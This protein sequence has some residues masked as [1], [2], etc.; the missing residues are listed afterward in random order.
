[1]KWVHAA[2]LLLSGLLCLRAN[3][4]GF[5]PVQARISGVTGSVLFSGGPGKQ[6]VVAGRG[7]PF[8][9]GNILDTT[10]GGRAVVSLSDGSVVIVQPGSV[11]TFKDFHQAGSLRE[12]FDIGLGQ[13][14]VK[15]NHF[16]GKPNPYRMNSPTASI[17]VRGTEFSITVDSAGGTKVVVFEGAVEVT[18]LSD[19]SRHALIEGGH[20]VFVVPGFD[21]QLFIPGAAD[22]ARGDN[23]RASPKTAGSQPTA[24]Q[25]QGA[26]GDRDQP[27]A[28]AQA[29]TYERYIAGLE[30]LDGLPLLLRYNALPE[31]W[32]DSAENPA[33]ATS[34]RNPEARLY[35][36]PSYGG[37]PETLEN[38]GNPSLSGN[39]SS[40]FTASAQ[41]SAFVPLSH[42]R[43][44]I[45]GSATGSYFNN[46]TGSAGSA[47]FDPGTFGPISSVGSL[48]SSGKSTSRFLDGS[49]LVAANTR[50][51]SFGAEVEQLA[52]N[53]SLTSTTPDPDMAGQTIK[54][55]L[56][57]SSIRQTR[58]TL[59]YHRDFTARLQFGIFGRYGFISAGNNDV[60]SLSGGTPKPLSQATSPGHTAEVGL[61]LRGEMTPKLFYGF[62]GAWFGLS[63]RDALSSG[64]LPASLQRDRERRESAGLG[65]A[66]LPWRRVVIA[67]DVAFG[68]S[69]VNAIR[70]QS[71][72]AVLLQNGIADSHFESLHIAVQRE[73]GRRFFAVGSYMNVWQGNT[74]SYS[75]FPD[76]SGM[77]QPLS[78][79]LF[80]TSPASYLSPRHFSDFGG[81]MRI[82]GDLL[83]QYIFST[84]YGYSSGSHTLMLRYTFRSSRK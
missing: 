50:L 72:S 71:G 69:H 3:G 21:F 22:L 12:L 64:G 9:P 20:A 61:R 74:L 55:S 63:L 37:T 65:V 19:P 25:G 15:I 44:V 54:D 84:D 47:D 6:K 34:F 31:A 13:V 66:Y 75:V 52:G 36:L 57:R 77:A 11:V 16:A 62:E 82:S 17:A 18:S 38:P 42:G 46:A 2:I 24:N 78:D 59:G 29:G 35:L 48:V 73:I 28:R 43:F 10:G 23:D 14:R 32:L 39:L 40:D 1:M 45:G 8:S 26:G 81:G 68:L 4:Q 58:L 79:Q 5:S 70:K 7:L 80:S 27:T 83:A 56:T 51:G 60:F 30:S 76:S 53:G 49:F 41:F 33:Y 67:A